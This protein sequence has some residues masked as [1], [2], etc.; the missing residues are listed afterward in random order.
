MQM[1]QVKF[2]VKK[3]T[4][5]ILDLHPLSWISLV[6]LNMALN[7]WTYYLKSACTLW[8]TDTRQTMQC[9][10]SSELLSSLNTTAPTA[11]TMYSFHLCREYSGEPTRSSDTIIINDEQ[12]VIT[13]TNLLRLP[14]SHIPQVSIYTCS[15]TVMLFTGM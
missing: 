7:M 10:A 14:S 15:M 12:N 8:C 2:F 11:N 13:W 9:H 5:K 4:T 1:L 3:T 6:N